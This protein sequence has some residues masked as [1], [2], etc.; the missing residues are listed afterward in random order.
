MFRKYFGQNICSEILQSFT[1]KDIQLLFVFSVELSVISRREK[2]EGWDHI[3]PIYFL[4]CL[5]SWRVMDGLGE[6]VLHRHKLPVK[7][8]VVG[9]QPSQNARCRGFSQDETAS[10]LGIAWISPVGM[11][12]ATFEC[13]S[14]SPCLNLLLLFKTRQNAG[15]ILAT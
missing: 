6:Q 13:F 4:E 14:S 2:K 7:I 10:L 11:S 3:Y 8:N 15:D 9:V 12:A 1:L 5:G